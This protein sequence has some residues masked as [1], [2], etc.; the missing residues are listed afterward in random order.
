MFER[1]NFRRSMLA[2]PAVNGCLQVTTFDCHVSSGNEVPAV[3]KVSGDRSTNLFVKV[4][5]L[6]NGILLTF[7]RTPRSGLHNAT[8]ILAFESL[9]TLV[10]FHGLATSP[11]RANSSIVDNCRRPEAISIQCL[12][13][14]CRS[15]SVFTGDGC[16]D[17]GSSSALKRDLNSDHRF[18]RFACLWLVR[19]LYCDGDR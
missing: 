5:Q 2:Y 3:W 17:S 1:V 4:G 16:R 10:G 13:S 18:R 15:P 19:S 8:H 7:A 14:E 12:P 6:Q 9:S 11:E